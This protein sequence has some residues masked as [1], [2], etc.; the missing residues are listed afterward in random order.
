MPDNPCWR[1]N[2][3]PCIWGC[4]GIFCMFVGWKEEISSSVTCSTVSTNQPNF[5]KRSKDL[6]A[7]QFCI[8][9]RFTTRNKCWGMYLLN[10]LLIFVGSMIFWLSWI[11]L[12]MVPF[13][14]KTQLRNSIIIFL[15]N[16][17]PYNISIFSEI[18]TK[19]I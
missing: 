15:L 6:N 13:I 12:R 17:R 8:E 19:V 14:V 16:R 7:C 1:I 2:R 5:K 9:R 3:V 4:N 11:L 18:Y 10:H